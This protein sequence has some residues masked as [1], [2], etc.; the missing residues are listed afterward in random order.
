MPEGTV[1]YPPDV[2][3]NQTEQLRQLESLGIDEDLRKT[4]VQEY[5]QFKEVFTEALHKMICNP[6]FFC[7][8]PI[9][10]MIE[11]DKNMSLEFM[12]NFRGPCKKFTRAV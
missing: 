7:T 6:E 2:F 3:M 5:H 9:I 8:R 4:A 1:I 12:L 10:H 11:Y